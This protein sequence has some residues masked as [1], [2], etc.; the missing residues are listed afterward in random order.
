VFDRLVRLL[1]SSLLRRA[2]RHY[3]DDLEPVPQSRLLSA[4]ETSF[5]NPHRNGEVFAPSSKR[6]ST[7]LINSDAYV[8]RADARQM[9]ARKEGLFVPRSNCPM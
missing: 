6:N 3:S 4:P 9:I 7:R 1:C 5:G 8:F 2:Q